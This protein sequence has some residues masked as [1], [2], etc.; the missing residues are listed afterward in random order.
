MVFYIHISP[1]PN[2]YS[3]KTKTKK[4]NSQIKATKLYSSQFIYC[5]YFS[6]LSKTNT[7]T[8]FTAKQKQKKPTKIEN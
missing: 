7:F 1:C 6:Y 5:F 3:P 8:Q 2:S 4:E